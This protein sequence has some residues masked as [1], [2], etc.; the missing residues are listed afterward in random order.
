MNN[1]LSAYDFVYKAMTDEDRNDL[2]KRITNIMVA[3]AQV[4][5]ETMKK[6]MQN[7]LSDLAVVPFHQAVQENATDY[8]W[9]KAIS[10]A[11][12]KQLLKSNPNDLEKYQIRQLV[13]A[14]RENYPEQFKT[15]MEGELLNRNKLL[16]DLV[17]FNSRCNQNRY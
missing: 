15:V 17:E 7:A 6:A 3:S 9:V 2:Q 5:T 13:D 1:P 4:A 12:W 16:E 14:W 8:E 11:L 10:D